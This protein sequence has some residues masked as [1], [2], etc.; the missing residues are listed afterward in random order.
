VRSQDQAAGAPGAQQK[1]PPRYA[2]QLL[3]TIEEDDV[4]RVKP[5]RK[6][7]PRLL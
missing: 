4:L 2:A 6:L 3:G 7:V 1:S 5:D